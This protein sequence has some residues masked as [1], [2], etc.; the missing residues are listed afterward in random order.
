MCPNT[1]RLG[2]AIEL[3]L[4][5]L[6]EVLIAQVDVTHRAADQEIV[7]GRLAKRGTV[8]RRKH[9]QRQRQPE[10]GKDVARSAERCSASRPAV[11]ERPPSG[12]CPRVAPPAH[13]TLD[14]ER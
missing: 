7:A 14:S 6:Q 9:E 1:G 3:A 4:D 8:R 10:R 12:T 2:D 11:E 5:E 13:S